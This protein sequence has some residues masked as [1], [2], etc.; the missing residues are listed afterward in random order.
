MYDKINVPWTLIKY[1]N[2][3]YALLRLGNR[4]HMD[5]QDIHFSHSESLFVRSSRQV[6]GGSRVLA[7]PVSVLFNRPE[8]RTEQVKSHFHVNAL[9]YFAAFFA[10]A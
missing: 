7:R 10:H 4:K 3:K 2:Q 1:F 9:K 6:R 5:I 8:A